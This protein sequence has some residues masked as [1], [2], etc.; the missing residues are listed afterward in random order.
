MKDAIFHIALNGVLKMKWNFSLIILLTILLTSCSSSNQRLSKTTDEKKADLYYSHGTAM[1]ISK[2]YRQALKLLLESKALNPNDPKVHNNLGMTYYFL[3]QKELAFEHLKKAIELDENGSD[4][5]VNL[6]SLYFEEK[7]YKLALEQYQEVLKNLTYIHQ[8]RTH[9]NIALI[10]LKMGNT[11]KAK[12]QLLLSNTQ[13]Q[14]YCPASYELGLIYFKE[15]RYS[16]ALKWFTESTKGKCFE[17]PEPAYMQALTLLELKDYAAATLKFQEL[18]ERF[19]AT[20]FS[21]MATLK[22]NEIKNQKIIEN[23]END[24]IRKKEKKAKNIYNSPSF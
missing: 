15:Y 12:E 4:A 20:R 19:S 6:G 21:S 23:K 3:K 16:S 11:T 1:L 5:R 10:Y 9:Y 13:N 24:I 2:D 18:I 14:D 8:Y 17:N 7:N 22:L